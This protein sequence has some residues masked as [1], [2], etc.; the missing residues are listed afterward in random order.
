[1]SIEG[2][3]AIDLRHW[4]VASSILLECS[5][6]RDSTDVSAGLEP[7]RMD[8]LVPRVD[9]AAAPAV[10]LVDLGLLVVLVALVVDAAEASSAAGADEARCKARPTTPSE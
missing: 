9:S 8:S 4:D 5:R 10:S 2:S 3:C 7:R 1:M 6:Q